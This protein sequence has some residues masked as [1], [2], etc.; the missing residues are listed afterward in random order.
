MDVTLR[1]AV[2]L[3][4]LTTSNECDTPGGQGHN[5]ALQVQLLQD[6]GG[7]GVRLHVLAVVV[8]DLVTVER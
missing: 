8:N 1:K 7:V 4:H 3:G 2:L 5:V 6:L